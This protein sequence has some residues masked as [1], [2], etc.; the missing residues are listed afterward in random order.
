MKTKYDK[1]RRLAL[2]CWKFTIDPEVVQKSQKI[3]R[4]NHRYRGVSKLSYR[5][6]EV[7]KQNFPEMWCENIEGY[8]SHVR[9]FAPE[10]QAF[11]MLER[12]AQL[13]EF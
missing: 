7:A 12:S 8:S 6:A 10:V 11:Y 13:R 5:K 9:V 1:L 3:S 4:G 2:N